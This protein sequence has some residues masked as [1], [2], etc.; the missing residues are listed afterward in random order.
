MNRRFA[1]SLLAV[2]LLA[3]PAAAVAAPSHPAPWSGAA[4]WWDALV[5]QVCS[6]V[7]PA[8]ATGRGS[9]PRST[10]R[11]RDHRLMPTCSGAMDPNGHCLPGTRRDRRL[12][13]TCSGAMDPDGRCH[14]NAGRGRRLTPTCSSG[15]DPNGHCF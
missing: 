9:E 2:L 3:V 8:A 15:M 11:G 5:A 1:A 12:N 13:P 4:A 14:T 10:S 6:A 7:V